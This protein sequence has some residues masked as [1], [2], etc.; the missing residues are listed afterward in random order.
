MAQRD[1]RG[2]LLGGHDAGEPR[3]LQRIAL[4]RPR[5]RGSAARAAATSLMSPRATA[6]RVGDRLV[7]DVDHPDAAASRRR[8]TERRRAYAIGSSR[9]ARERTTGSRATRV[10]STLFSFTSARHLQRAGREVE[11]R[12]DARRRPPGRRRAARPAPARRS[13]RCRCARCSTTFLSSPDVVDRHAAARLA[14][15]PSRSAMSNSATISKPSWRKPGIVGEREAE[16]AGAHDRDAQLAIEAEDLPQVAPQILDVVADAADAELAEVREVLADLR[17]VEVELLGER[18]RRDG[19]DAGGFER[20]EAAQVDR[21]AVGGE[22]G[23]LIA[24]CCPAAARRRFVRLF[25]QA[26]RRL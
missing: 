19:L 7:A 13:R 18:L 15:R 2:G 4:L 21:Q 1:E 12:L 23:D 9:L 25:S 17:G 16:V 10:R 20:V 24:L 26:Q 8:A 3:G 14:G 5:P 11:D 22:L 6:S